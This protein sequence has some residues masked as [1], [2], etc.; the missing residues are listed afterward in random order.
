MP[1][2]GACCCCC[3]C[4]CCCTDPPC[5]IKPPGSPPAGFAAAG[6]PDPAPA[7]V[8][9]A[10]A[11]P[12][13]VMPAANAAALAAANAAAA[14]AAVSGWPKPPPGPAAAVGEGAAA[15]PA[16]PHRPAGTIMGAREIPPMGAPAGWLLGANPGI[17]GAPPIICAAEQQSHA[18]TKSD[19]CLQHQCDSVTVSAMCTMGLFK[20]LCMNQGPAFICRCKQ[21][22][23]LHLC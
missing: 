7:G 5:C 22:C 6:G 21:S 10:A 4:C 18:A 20:E 17:P 19:T 23:S 8:P 12:G 2:P 3:C 13:G 11:P 1:P 16:D 14:M 9:A 15:P